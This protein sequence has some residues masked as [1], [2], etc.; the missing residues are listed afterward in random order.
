MTATDAPDGSTEGP[1]G[2]PFG[3]YIGVERYPS[4]ADRT[5]A[6]LVVEPHHLNPTGAIHGGVLISLADNTATAMANH[7]NVEANEGRFMVGIDLHA[8]MLANQ[9][10]GEVRAEARV[11]RQGRRVTVIRTAVTGEGGRV[12]AEVTT[13][14]I[15]A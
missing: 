3:N 12:L 1:G 9:Q 10:G 2:S 6:R 14:H 5:V 13:T 8:V 15:P 4:Q 7:A 11:V